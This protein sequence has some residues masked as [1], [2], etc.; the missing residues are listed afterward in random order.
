MNDS[1]NPL[2]YIVLAILIA[3]AIVAAVVRARRQARR[4]HGQAPA[5]SPEALAAHHRPRWSPKAEAFGSRPEH[6]AIALGAPFALCRGADQ[7]VLRFRDAAEE[8]RILAEAWGITDRASML[9]GLYDLLTS[10][11]RDRFGAEIAGW[12]ALDEAGARAEEAELREG[13]KHSD[14]GAEDLWR[15]RRVRA[16][17]RGIRSV[18]FLAWDLVR[19]A[20]L[21]R[22]GATTGYLSDAEATDVLMMIVPDIREHY[23]SWRELGE[24]F[25]LG[26]WYWNSQG[27]AGEASTDQH[28]LSRQEALMS[29]DSP[30]ARLPWNADVPP[31]RM[32]LASALAAGTQLRAWEPNEFPGSGWAKRLNDKVWRVRESQR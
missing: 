20:M 11:H 18:D 10:G 17:D 6:W 15:F 14:E 9:I 3:A 27:G 25:R 8:R 31:S 1:D 21:A 2:L 19:F 23:G 26:R 28:D 7:D 22:A 5:D 24:S 32:L 13:A 12:G 16:N 4:A 30:W 29:E